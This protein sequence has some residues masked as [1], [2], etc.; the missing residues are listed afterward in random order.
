MIEERVYRVYIIKHPIN[1]GDTKMN[2][3]DTLIKKDPTRG[4]NQSLLDINKE[5]P[6]CKYIKSYFI[7]RDNKNISYYIAIIEY[8]SNYFCYLT[9]LNTE[10]Q[11]YSID[12]QSLKVLSCENEISIWI[13]KCKRTFKG[14]R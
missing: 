12:V 4:I 14:N 8:K 7:G 5:I 2:N 1:L 11:L 13:D 6:G 10:K 9:V 3:L